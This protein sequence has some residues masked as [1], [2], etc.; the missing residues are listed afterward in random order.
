MKIIKIKKF[1]IYATNNLVLM[2]KK[3]IITKL[4]IIVN[5][6]V[7]T[8]VLSIRFVDQNVDH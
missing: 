7:S 5:L 6:L 4:K 2:M 8:K 1:S 3:K